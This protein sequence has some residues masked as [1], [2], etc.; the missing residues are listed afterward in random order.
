MV[1]AAALGMQLSSD[2]R[3][4]QSLKLNSEA[5]P[6]MG[7]STNTVKYNSNIDQQDQVSQI[8]EATSVMQDRLNNVST[9]K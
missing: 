1:H 9:T 8:N 2:C 3:S 4:M 5:E 7:F 6:M